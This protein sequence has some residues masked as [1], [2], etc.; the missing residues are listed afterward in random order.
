MAKE[1]FLLLPAPEHEESEILTACSLRHEA[2]FL[3]FVKERKTDRK[4]V[5]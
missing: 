4:N 2:K 3:I 1:M 5:E